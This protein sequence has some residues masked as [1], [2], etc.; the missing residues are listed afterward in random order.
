[1]SGFSRDNKSYKITK[2]SKSP[3]NSSAC[4]RHRSGAG[5]HDRAVHQAPYNSAGEILVEM[6]GLVSRS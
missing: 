3:S 6:S 4:F 2:G 5:R 1:M